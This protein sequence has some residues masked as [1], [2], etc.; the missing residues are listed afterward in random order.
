MVRFGVH[1]KFKKK[2]RK[3]A[4]N[5]FYSLLF[6]GI[7]LNKRVV[8]KSLQKIKKSNSNFT[9]PRIST[10]L[11]SSFPKQKDSPTMA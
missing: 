9:C 7:E 10:L 2:Q 11:C 1:Q 5:N 4:E 3:F 6:Y 8:E